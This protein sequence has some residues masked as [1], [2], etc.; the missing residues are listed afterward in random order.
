ML[1]W[2]VEDPFRVETEEQ[3]DEPPAATS[4]TSSEF[5]GVPFGVRNS[6]DGSVANMHRY[7][8]KLYFIIE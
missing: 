6:I 2:L 8:N 5:C 7:I 3:S 4:T 1:R